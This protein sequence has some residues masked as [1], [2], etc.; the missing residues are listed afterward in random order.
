MLLVLDGE[1]KVKPASSK[2]Y[3]SILRTR[4]LKSVIIIFNSSNNESLT[5]TIQEFFEDLR[6]K[7]KHAEVSSLVVPKMKDL[8]QIP[9]PFFILTKMNKP[10]R[11]IKSTY[12]LVNPFKPSILLG[13]L[14]VWGSLATKQ[15]RSVF[16]IL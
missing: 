3:T 14:K 1:V 10:M 4:L 11:L 6:E 13:S 5:F 16:K 2:E 12:F 9:K 7:S 8:K 15:L